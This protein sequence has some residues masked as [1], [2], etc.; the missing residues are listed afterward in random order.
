MTLDY[1]NPKHETARPPSRRRRIITWIIGLPVAILL[2]ATILLPDGRHSP[3]TS[4]RFQC[5]SNLRQIGQA[6]YL[7]ANDNHGQLPPD[8]PTILQTQDIT[9]EVFVCPSSKMSTATGPTTQRVVASLIAGGHL[10]Y[11]W[12]GAGLTF[13][14]SPNVVLAFELESHAKESASP[15]GM[16]VLLGDQSVN[17]VNETT[18][19]SIRAQFA[20]GVRPIR[21]STS[22]PWV[23]TRPASSP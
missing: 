13:P 20:A 21:L 19:S 7:Y 17:F 15:A 4:H 8:L 14:Q 18:A 11:V 16:N 5:A 23:A 1:R 2:L 22:I 6:A 10:S 3:E 12:A 9:A